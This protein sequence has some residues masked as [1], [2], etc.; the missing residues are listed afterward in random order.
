MRH[1]NP[2]GTG[3]SKN[4]K[5]FTLIELLIM[6]AIIAVLAAMLLPALNAAREKAKSVSCLNHFQQVG[7]AVLFYLGDWADFYPCETDSAPNKMRLLSCGRTDRLISDYLKM[8]IDVPYIG[9]IRPDGTRSPLACPSESRTGTLSIGY[10]QYFFRPWD[11]DGKS[12][13]AYK[14]SQVKRPTRTMLFAEAPPTTINGRLS[15]KFIPSASAGEQYAYRH[16]SGIVTAFADSHAV[17]L[18]RSQFPHI[19]SGY[20]GYHPDAWL[21][22]FWSVTGNLDL[23]F[24]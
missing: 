4:V 13:Y 10:N 14:S 7:K 1:Q 8:E 18:R 21:C 12:V 6:I 20:P 15:Y 23:N 19:T 17:V 2:G 22:I 9:Q 3:M 5:R 11:Y 24:Y 16:G